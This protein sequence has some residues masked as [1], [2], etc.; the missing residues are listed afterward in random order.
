MGVLL[1]PPR[2]CSFTAVLVTALP[3]CIVSV[4]SASCLWLE[5]I[6]ATN[7]WS[8]FQS[9]FKHGREALE[10]SST[11]SPRVCIV[12]FSSDTKPR[13]VRS[14]GCL[15]IAN[16]FMYMAMLEISSFNRY[17]KLRKDV[18]YPTIFSA[19]ERALVKSSCREDQIYLLVNR[20]VY[21]DCLGSKTECWCV[22]AH[23]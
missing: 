15:L 17:L 11:R 20:L 19:S 21:R 13:A 22:I 5:W 4:M 16:L 18:G 8:V 14:M 10:M 3:V 9:L 23:V 6:S 1:P 2:A 7:S 12:W